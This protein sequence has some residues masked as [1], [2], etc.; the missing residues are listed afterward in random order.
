MANN[1]PGFGCFECRYEDCKQLP[2]ILFLDNFLESTY[3]FVGLV[4]A[5]FPT[6]KSVHNC[7]V[8][9]RVINGRKEEGRK[10]MELTHT[11]KPHSELADA[12]R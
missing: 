3:Q 10:T 8:E 12:S 11:G 7:P 1:K 4:E 2:T 9:Y 5:G 6:S